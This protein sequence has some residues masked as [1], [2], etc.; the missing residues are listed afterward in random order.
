MKNLFRAIRITFQYPVTLVAAVICSFL[1][2]G[3][4]GANIGAVY[5][6]VEVV[7][8]N[9]SMKQWVEE[10][11]ADLKQ[12]IADLQAKRELVEAQNVVELSAIDNQISA[13]EQSLAQRQ[14]AQPYIVAYMPE[15]PFTTLGYVV[16]FLLVGTSVKV[17]FL[18]AHMLLVERL[19]QKAS[20][21]LRT[22][23]FSHMLDLEL[24][25]HKSEHSSSI[26]TRIAS[27]TFTISAAITTLFG[28]TMRE[29]MKMTACLIGAAFIS[30]RLL[31][32]SLLITPVALYLLYLLAKSIKRANRR[33]MEELQRVF[34]RLSETFQAVAVV[35]AFTMEQAEKN[36]FVQTAQQL[37]TRTMKVA[38]YSSLVRFNNE[39]L[40]VGVFCLAILAG[41]YLVLNQE[42]HLLG[43]KITERPLSF[44]AIMLFYAF[45]LGVSDPIRKLA[46]VYNQLQA[47]A[48]SADRIFPLLDRQPTVVDVANPKPAPAFENDIEFCDVKFSYQVDEQVLRGVDLKIQAGETVAIVGPN[49]CGKST[50]VNL[51]PRF[52]DVDSGCINIDGVDIRQ[53]ALSDLRGAMSVVT[54]QTTLFDESVIDNI[55][56][57]SPEATDLQVV[58]AAKKAHAHG[59]IE[60]KLENGYDTI[61]GE[62]GENLSGGQRQ[63]IALARAILRDARL[64]ILDEATSQIDPESEQLIHQALA[65]FV[66]DRTAIM[67]THRLTTLDL[68]DRIVVM[69]SGLIVD[70]G[71]HAELNERCETY[72]RLYQSG[73]HKSA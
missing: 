55:R 42:T 25:S 18:A 8:Q 24:A 3:L 17:I 9:K 58:A 16:V 49:G 50:L 36:R 52:Y 20:L 10:E 15:D 37:Y 56:Y 26:T 35:K 23:T 19:G 57:G 33:T 53:L 59:F 63:R 46:D 61:V 69:E 40:G 29:P 11:I 12:N 4:W 30:W 28:K 43:I 72:Q 32:V 71:T 13:E 73:F 45:L 60:S 66:A 7:F 41:G 47:G 54:Q 6:I 64:L 48:A 2:A 22:K 21:E 44:G 62:K 27:D 31:A 39:L 70:V 5:P 1:V 14:W 67:I 38:W 65:D 34:A 68:A 51:L